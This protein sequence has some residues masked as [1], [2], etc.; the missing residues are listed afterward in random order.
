MKKI[1][2]LL[3]LACLFSCNNSKKETRFITSLKKEAT[4]KQL[5]STM[6]DSVRYIRLETIDQSLLGHDIGKI[7]KK[8]NRYYI[9]CDRKDLYVFDK[10]GS[11]IQH[12]NKRG[13]GPG[14]YSSISDYDVLDNGT[15]VILDV[16]KLHFY[17]KDG[18]FQK[19]VPLNLSIF[20][21]KVIS[22]ESI[23]LFSSG[24]PYFIYETDLSG[25]IKQQ[26]YKND[27]STALGRNI[28]FIPLGN[29]QIIVQLG[30]SNDF[31]LYDKPSNH[32][33]EIRLVQD[34]ILSY[35][36][37]N[38]LIDQ[39]GF[40]YLKQFPNLKFLDAVAGNSKDLLFGCGSQ[41]TGFTIQV[42]DNTTKTLKYVISQND[43]DD[44]SFTSAFFME[45]ACLSD[46]DDCFITYVHPFNVKAGIEKQKD[47]QT[48]KEYIRVNDLFKD[49]QEDDNMFLIEFRFK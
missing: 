22:K 20:N 49:V 28:V 26:Y 12:L 10:N 39:Y 43:I 27:Q 48:T 3:V 40:K 38:D 36:R 30:R 6:L 18:Y 31:I 2:S 1:V 14:E 42:Y 33:E 44:V 15:V 35:N 16:N 25:K 19:T 23:L 13:M 21:L 7:K 9:S 37:E 47:L 24:E 41:E 8:N 34:D 4:E 11:F 29:E 5:I 17:D 45:Y 46:A 32:F